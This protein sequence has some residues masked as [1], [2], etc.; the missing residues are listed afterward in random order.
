MAAITPAEKGGVHADGIT[1]RFTGT[2]TANQADT[3]TSPV[4]PERSAQKLLFA[5]CSYSAAPT[6]AGVTFELDSGAGA[7]FD[8][9]LFTGAANALD[10]VYIP[11]HEIR[12]VPG[13]AIKVSA[14]AGGGGITANISI[15][16]DQGGAY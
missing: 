14:P 2:G 4:C 13:D 8:S 3:M 6:Q 5:A 9:V 15:Y 7:D 10:T 11:D 16:L 12:I 1:K